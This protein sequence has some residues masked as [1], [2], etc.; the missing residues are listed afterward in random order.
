MAPT[1][2]IL[3]LFLKRTD[4]KNLFNCFFKLM[5]IMLSGPFRLLGKRVFRYLSIA[6]SSCENAFVEYEMT[7]ARLCIYVSEFLLPNKRD[8]KLIA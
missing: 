4:K 6:D 7:N 3:G 2:V 1:L 5:K 8:M